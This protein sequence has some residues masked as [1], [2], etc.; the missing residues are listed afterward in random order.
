MSDNIL[1]TVKINNIVNSLNDNKY[2]LER[3]DD[4]YRIKIGLGGQTENNKDKLEKLSHK[5]HLSI[6]TLESSIIILEELHTQALPF[7]KEG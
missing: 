6:A 7:D 3:L 2:E 4:E 5:I 1:R